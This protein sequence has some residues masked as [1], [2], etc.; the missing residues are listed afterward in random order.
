LPRV[1]ALGFV[2]RRPGFL[3]KAR[4]VV[5]SPVRKLLRRLSFRPR[6]ATTMDPNDRAYLVNL[7]RDDI[8]R[9]AEL[10]GRDLSMWLK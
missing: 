3:K 4:E 10:L 8:R 9:L 5:P 6:D 7:Y 2:L 1:S